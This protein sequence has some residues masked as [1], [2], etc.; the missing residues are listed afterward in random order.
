MAPSPS[1]K[2]I[3]TSVVLMPV[4]RRSI[5]PTLVYEYGL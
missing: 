4:Q 2:A 1:V 3:K 5:E